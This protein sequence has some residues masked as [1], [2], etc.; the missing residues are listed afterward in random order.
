MKGSVVGPEDSGRGFT[1]GGSGET[2]PP[3]LTPRNCHTPYPP[4]TVV[5]DRLLLL[6]IENFA[7]VGK[8]LP[9]T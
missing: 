3:A 2:L 5:A 9:I 4:A 1:S 8:L 7:A 6:Q